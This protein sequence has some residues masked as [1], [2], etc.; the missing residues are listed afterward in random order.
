MGQVR[1]LKLAL[2]ARIGI[3][4]ETQW[5]II[6][7]LVEHACL[8]INR[9][10]VGHDG[11][12]PHRRLMGKEPTQPLWEFGEQILAKPLRQKKIKR[13]IFLSSKWLKGTWVGLT[14]RSGENIVVLAEG[15]PA[16]CV[17]TVMRRQEEERRKRDQQNHRRTTK[18]I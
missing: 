6:D 5:G 12:T 2:E 3:P 15:G 7:W 8:T 16:I 1:T 17:R 10:Q 18:N 11:K 14:S 4:V 9:G 13:K